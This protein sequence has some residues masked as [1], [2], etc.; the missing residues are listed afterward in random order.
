MKVI[1]S[2]THSVVSEQLLG[3]GIV[4]SARNTMINETAL[5]FKEPWPEEADTLKDDYKTNCG[6]GVGEEGG[7]MYGEA[8]HLT[9]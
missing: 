1:H 3:P 6:Q 5:V 7:D 4:L 9:F 2:P 8:G